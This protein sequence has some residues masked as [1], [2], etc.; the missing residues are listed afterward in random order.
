MPRGCRR[1]PPRL[2]APG[3]RASGTRRARTGKGR[4]ARCSR[5]S[6]PR[7]RTPG[8]RAFRGSLRGEP[9]GRRRPA[10][11]NPA[12]ALRRKALCTPP[13]PACPAPSCRARGCLP[14]KTQRKAALKGSAAGGASPGS[15]HGAPKR[16]PSLRD[17]GASSRVRGSG[18][19]ARRDGLP[20]ARLREH[21][22]SSMQSSQT[23]GRCVKRAAPF[24][25]FFAR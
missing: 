12:P 19:R 11:R 5:D 1:C 20:A 23:C 14:G 24:D 10:G 9:A 2:P 13:V 22:N 17:P 6:S 18:F 21:R 4:A 7:G 16:P 25:L 8:A 15:F 3:C